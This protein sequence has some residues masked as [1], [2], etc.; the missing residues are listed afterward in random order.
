MIP[1]LAS[2]YGLTSSERAVVALVMQGLSSREISDHLMITT[3][4]VHDRLKAV[5]RKTGTNGRGP[6]RH[7][8]ALETWAQ[9][10][11]AEAT[12]PACG[13][14]LRSAAA[15]IESKVRDWL[16]CSRARR[17][18]SCRAGFRRV[19][20]RSRD[21]MRGVPQT[22]PVSFSHLDRSPARSLPLPGAGPCRDRG[23]REDQGSNDRTRAHRD[24]GCAGFGLNVRSG[25]WRRR[26]ET[27][28]F[29]H[30]VPSENF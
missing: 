18:E 6:L 28:R 3:D 27:K 15:C 2:A 21:R 23:C 1:I 12:E 14:T 4:T 11:S 19:V 20:R 29:G 17:R 25:N 26:V 5:Y 30:M 10:H 7:R 13:S 8:L 9:A 16:I 24:E 22:E